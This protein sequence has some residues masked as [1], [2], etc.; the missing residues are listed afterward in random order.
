MALTFTVES[1]FEHIK[2]LN[3]EAIEAIGKSTDKVERRNLKILSIL[4]S[5]KKPMSAKG[6]DEQDVN[7]LNE[8]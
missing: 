6:W 7:I 2:I 3:D 4:L 5:A 8:Q 1:A